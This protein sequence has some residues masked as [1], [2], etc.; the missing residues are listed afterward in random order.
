MFCPFWSSTLIYHCNGHLEMKDYRTYGRT[1]NRNTTP[2][3]M[4]NRRSIIVAGVVFRLQVQLTSP[5]TVTMQ[6]GIDE[7]TIMQIIK[8]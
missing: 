1:N 5:E 8:E 2:A 4:M 7:K 3:T 6:V